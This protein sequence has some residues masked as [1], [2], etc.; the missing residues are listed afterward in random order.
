MEF[1][2]SHQPAWTQS[3][4]ELK[5]DDLPFQ[6]ARF[7]GGGGLGVCYVFLDAFLFKA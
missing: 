4:N 3:E 6:S 5:F 1:P 2:S 7:G